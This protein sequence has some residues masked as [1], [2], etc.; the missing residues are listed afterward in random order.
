V[1]RKHCHVVA[2]FIGREHS[3][4]PSE[5]SRIRVDVILEN[6][7]LAFALENPI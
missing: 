4:C 2:V 6:D 5:E 3:A 7:G 1:A